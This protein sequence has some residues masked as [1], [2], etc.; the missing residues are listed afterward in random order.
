MYHHQGATEAVCL[1]L[2]LPLLL[3]WSD[4]RHYWRQ[5]HG[6]RKSS[7]KTRFR[8]RKRR[9]RRAYDWWHFFI[10]RAEAADCIFLPAVHR[11]ERM[12]LFSQTQT[13]KKCFFKR[14]RNFSMSKYKEKIVLFRCFILFHPPCVFQR[15]MAISPSGECLP[16]S[17][18]SLP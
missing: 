16:P 13:M 6:R 14:S 7:G 4:C 12:C 9:R 5:N 3:P 18:S 17:S 11:V 2:P 8:K 1:L 10:S 15:S